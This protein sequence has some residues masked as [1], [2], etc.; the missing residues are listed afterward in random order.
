MEGVHQL[1]HG[2]PETF[3]LVTLS[4]APDVLTL[5]LCFQD[6]PIMNVSPPPPEE[7]S[8][9]PPGD[10]RDLP[11]GATFELPQMLLERDRWAQSLGKS[12][13][14]RSWVGPRL[15]FSGT[16]P[17]QRSSPQSPWPLLQRPVLCPPPVLFLSERGAEEVAQGE[18]AC[19]AGVQ[20]PEPT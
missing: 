18:R 16:L 2:L 6:G 3:G 13:G 8:G 10:R 7:T 1:S 4:C 9:E 17:T 11:W 5:L 15:W 19:F 12:E 14:T 20:S